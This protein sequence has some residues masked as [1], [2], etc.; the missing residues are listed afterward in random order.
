MSKTDHLAKAKDYIAIAES[1]DSKREAYAKAGAEI[2]A[3]L[4]EDDT[5]TQA[6]AARQLGTNRMAV[7]RALQAHRTGELD[8]RSGTNKRDEVTAKVLRDA[9]PETI[10]EIVR[11]LPREQRERL[12]DASHDVTI[13][14]MRAKRAE[15]DITRDPTTRDLMGGERFD[16]SETWADALIVRVQ[17]AAHRLKKRVEREGLRLGSLEIEEAFEMLNEAEANV[18]EVRAAVQER[19]RDGVVA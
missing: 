4:A 1:N 15:H 12:I 2:E 5:R 19:I 17:A 16:P 7:T 14:E 13:D 8:F 11:E 18:A 9:P 3:W 6:D 10:R